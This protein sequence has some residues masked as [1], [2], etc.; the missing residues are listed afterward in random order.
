MSAGS[1]RRS[2]YR[3]TYVGQVGDLFLQR[4]RLDREVVRR[5]VGRADQ[6]V[7]VPGNREDRRGRRRWR[8]TKRA[9]SPGM[10][11]RSRTRW[12]PWLSVK[13]GA[14]P[15]SSSRR[16]VSTNTPVALITARAWTVS[17]RPVS[18]SRA[19]SP[20]IRPSR[21][22][23]LVT[24]RVVEGGSPQV[25]QRSRQRDRQPGVV[26]LPVGVDDSAVETSAA[27]RGN[28]LLDLGS[29]NPVR[30][31]EPQPAGKQVVEL[32]ARSIIG[33]LVPVVCG[34][35]EVARVHELRCVSKQDSAL[36]RVPRAPGRT[37]P[38]AR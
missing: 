25:G 29:G 7:V 31:A 10:N 1:G 11:D 32:E 5:R 15:A 14:A 18:T 17:S 21:L 19:I 36:A 12:A 38:C 35:H 20:A 6:D 23:K 4:A 27:N 33:Q 28:P 24:G 16:K 2:R 13:S 9:V 37:F 30:P 22:V 26:K 34:H 3:P 8:G